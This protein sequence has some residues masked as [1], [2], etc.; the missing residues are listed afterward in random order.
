METTVVLFPGMGYGVDRP[1]F[2]YARQQARQHGCEVV[3]AAYPAFDQDPALPL[4]QRAAAMLPGCV[5]RVL[6]QLED[7]C[8]GRCVFVSKSLGTLVAGEAARRLGLQ[9]AQIFLTP[10]PQ[11]Y[12]QYMRGRACWAV[13]G[14]ADPLMTRA[15]AGRMRRDPAVHLTAV[16]RANHSLEVPGDLMASVNALRRVARLYCA[17]F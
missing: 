14:T 13:Y 12:E 6:E 2:Y 3:C 16:A 4:E 5:S 17:L 7:R 8:R 15:C 9:P 10:L 11:T 1:L